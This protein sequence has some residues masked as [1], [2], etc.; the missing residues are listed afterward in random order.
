MANAPSV[1]RYGDVAPRDFGKTTR[2]DTRI[3]DKLRYDPIMET[4]YMYGV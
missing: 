3:Q 4:R 2:D 1:R